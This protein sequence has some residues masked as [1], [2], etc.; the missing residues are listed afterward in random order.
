MTNASSSDL[1]ILRSLKSAH[2]KLKE[3]T[4]RIAHMGDINLDD[5]KYLLAWIDDEI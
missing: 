2:G 1:E 4:F 5:L 3:E